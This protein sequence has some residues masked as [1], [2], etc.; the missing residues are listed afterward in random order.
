MVLEDKCLSKDP[1]RDNGSQSNSEF[2]GEYGGGIRKQ[3]FYTATQDPE[4][5]IRAGVKTL[6]LDN[7]FNMKPSLYAG[8]DMGAKGV[9][10]TGFWHHL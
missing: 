7:I 3:Q 1:V 8:K 6:L 5:K 4:C 9:L 2:V 10:V